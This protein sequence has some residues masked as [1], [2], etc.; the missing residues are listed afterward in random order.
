MGNFC[1]VQRKPNITYRIIHGMPICYFA[2]AVTYN[3]IISGAEN[4]FPEYY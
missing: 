4:V 3:F 2:L 1:F